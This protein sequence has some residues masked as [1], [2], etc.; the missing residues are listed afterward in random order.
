MGFLSKAH[1]G[2]ERHDSRILRHIGHTAYPVRKQG[3]V[4]TGVRL[5][6]SHFYSVLDSSPWIDA[7]MFTVDL[8][9]PINSVQKLLHTHIQT[10]VSMVFLN[11]V[12]LTIKVNHHTYISSKG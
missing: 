4:N 6:L 11:P 12:K 8:P 7:T 1:H 10:F 2:K 5:S 3:Q 9:P